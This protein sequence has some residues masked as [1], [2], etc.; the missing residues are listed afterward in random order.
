MEK[1]GGRSSEQLKGQ[2]VTFTHQGSR[3]QPGIEKAKRTRGPKEQKGKGERVENGEA[4]FFRRQEGI[5]INTGVC[6]RNRRLPL[7]LTLQ[8]GT[9]SMDSCV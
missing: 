9:A 7:F 8:V 4:M 2:W 3:A 5:C 6:E 1:E